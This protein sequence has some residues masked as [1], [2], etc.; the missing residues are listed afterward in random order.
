MSVKVRGVISI[1]RK[2]SRRGDFNVG[3][4]NTEIGEFE[5]KDSIIDEFEPGKYEGEFIIRWIQPD[6]FSWKGRVYVKNKA[7]LEAIFIFNADEG[8][9]PP[10]APPEPDPIET[11]AA[12]S[13]PG[14]SAQPVQHH[15]AVLEVAPTKVPEVATSSSAAALATDPPAADTPADGSTSGQS[16]G[17]AD[18]IDPDVVLFGNELIDDVRRTSLVK[19]DPTV[20]REKFRAQRD[21]LKALGY[22]FDAKAQSWARR[23]T[24]MA[25]I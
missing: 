21:R 19:L 14:D 7:S 12:L 20:D 13:L 11:R 24:E 18:D 2:S 10:A 23:D 17:Q 22:A 1:T 4:L 9:A 6:S 5:V 15:E 3:D 8:A 25:E 16:P